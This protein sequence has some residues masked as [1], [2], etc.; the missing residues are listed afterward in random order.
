MCTKVEGKWKSFERHI[1]SKERERETSSPY[2]RVRERVASYFFA[3][4]HH[5]RQHARVCAARCVLSN[6]RTERKKLRR[7]SFFP[8]RTTISAAKNFTVRGDSEMLKLSRKKA[9]DMQPGENNDANDLFVI[10][11]SALVFSYPRSPGGR[12]RAL[13]WRD[14]SAR[15]F[16]QGGK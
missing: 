4:V 15:G 12:R 11:Q 3:L 14:A 16:S 7:F 13:R 8:P 5:A 2:T 9:V 1:E 6:L 10:F